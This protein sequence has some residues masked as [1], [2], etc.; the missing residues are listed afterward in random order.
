MTYTVR[1]VRKGAEH[2]AFETT[3]F[4][5]PE[6]AYEYDLLLPP[7]LVAIV[8]TW[9]IEGTA[10]GAAWA[11]LKAKIEDSKNFPDGIEL[12]RDGNVLESI[13]V[14][15]DYD[16]WRIERLSSSRSDLQWRG[17]HRYSMRIVG[18]R[19]FGTQNK[20]SDLK[21]TETWSYDETGL[22]TRTLSG[23]LDV[24]DGSAVAEARKLG[25]KIPGKTFAFVTNGPEGV[26]V[27]RL[28]PGDLKARFTST[29]R[30]SGLALPDGVGPG[31]TLEVETAVRDGIQVT[32][33]R[34]HGAGPGALA[35]VQSH[36]APGRHH[37]SISSD[38]HTR[39][40]QGVFVEARPASG[41]QLLRLHRFSVSGGNRPVAFTR[42][43]GGRLPVEHTLSFTSVDVTESIEVLTW[44][45][46]A[47]GK[48]RLPSPVTGLPEDRDAWRLAG[49]ERTTIGKDETADEWT[50]HVTRVYRASSLANVFTP[51]LQSVIAPGAGTTLD[52]EITRITKV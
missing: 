27:E 10:Y 22:L 14:A 38:S 39:T 23:E 3:P 19:R 25:L 33:T 44:G 26:D 20:I 36:L 9:T 42:R 6:H 17:E 49:P 45:K 28:D 5:A 8:K 47:T 34:V 32:T 4:V 51:V 46:P 29:I 41:D 18:R 13:T 24:T 30:E 43:T 35:A 31:F 2:H 52:D 50:T 16:D 7:N 11:S 1:F 12:L 37:E 40:A 15:G 21:Q 48:I